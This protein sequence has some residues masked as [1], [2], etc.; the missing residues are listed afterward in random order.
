MHTITGIASNY[1]IGSVRLVNGSAA[2]E[3]R[4]EIWYS[5]QWHTVV[6]IPGVL[7]M[8]LL[9]VGNLGIKRQHMPTREP[10]LAKDLEKSSW[11]I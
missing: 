5:D 9:R 1:S 3:G 8:P 6:M 2:N 4:V 10:I 11:T 7:L